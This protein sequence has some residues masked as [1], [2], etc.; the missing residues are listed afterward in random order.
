MKFKVKLSVE[1]VSLE[2]LIIGPPAYNPLINYLKRSSGL[3]LYFRELYELSYNATPTMRKEVFKKYQDSIM[4]VI[5][6]LAPI[7]ASYYKTLF[8]TMEFSDEEASEMTWKMFIK[9]VEDF[10]ETFYDLYE[11]EHYLHMVKNPTLIVS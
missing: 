6:A 7:I 8:V 1:E 11:I 5:T 2:N 3:A 4:G 9:K 10:A